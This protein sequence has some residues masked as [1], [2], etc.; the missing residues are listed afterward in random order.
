MA[1]KKRP[2]SD[3]VKGMLLEGNFGMQN[4]T[5]LPMTD[6]VSTTQMVLT[7]D[8]IQQYDKNP[9]R[10]RNP[11]YENIKESIRSKKQ[12]NN[13]FNVTRRPGDD[14]YMI[15]SGGNTRLEILKEL[16]HETGDEAFNTIHCL[17]VPW[18]SEAEVLSAHLIENEMRGD[19]TLIDKAYA[20]QMLKK[21]LEE[22]TGKKL[23]DREFT[24]AAASLGYTI[25]K[26]LLI[27]FN[28]ARYLDQMIPQVL[29][30]GLGG[31]KID[32]IKKVEKAYADY[33]VGKTEQFELIFAE[34]MAE[35]DT[36]EYWDFDKIVRPELDEKLA[37]AT[38]IRKNLLR[39][40]VDGILFDRPGEIDF[41]APPPETADIKPPE[42][43]GVMMDENSVHGDGTDFP[44][45]M[46]REQHNE[47]SVSE[48]LTEHDAPDT[49]ADNTSVE[50]V[51][52]EEQSEQSDTV[53]TRAVA[54]STQ[55]QPALQTPQAQPPKC[56]PIHILW[57][58]GYEFALKIA[59][60]AGL[61]DSYI[62]PAKSGMGFYLERP[63]EQ[64][65]ETRPIPGDK[66]NVEVIHTIPSMVW[67]L[68]F[69]SAEQYDKLPKSVWGYTALNQALD[70]DK[71]QQELAFMLGPQPNSCISM[72][73][74]NTS[75]S[76]PLLHDI[77]MLISN[78]RRI[79]QHYDPATI[80]AESNTSHQ[81]PRD[82]QGEHQ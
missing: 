78:S 22:E 21:E 27:R 63:P 19:M 77:F 53:N 80:W 11:E 71:G 74:Q 62:L 43:A 47:P 75:I 38:G 50:D 52:I 7:L 18:K 6:P 5:A 56:Q 35:T 26:T 58:K 1:T 60:K 44:A 64:L 70:S 8:D 14:K 33:C 16:Y 69:D 36:D 34:V 48:T 13:N 2:D 54:D 66:T 20:V 28:Y 73:L 31:H 46:L 72:L 37:E 3:A 81:L 65:I 39:L 68:L 67:W 59:T 45:E 40:E 15:E 76:D 9:R 42:F 57:D 24:R 4:D 10:E 82:T 51:V 12:L 55:D 23:S 41:A 29:K 17:F 61:N 79:K 30:Q 49:P 32:R 25:S